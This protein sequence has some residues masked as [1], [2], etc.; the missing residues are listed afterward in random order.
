IAATPTAATGAT[1][2]TA[3]SAPAT[4]M[5]AERARA[6]VPQFIVT[7]ANVAAVAGICRQLDGLPL[8]LELAAARVKVLPP[9]ALLARLERAL[10]LLA[11]GPRD[12]PARQRTMRDALAWS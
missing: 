12:L 1:V 3:M 8:A 7:E 6:V 9:T 10:P 11:D 2:A 5:F 4:R